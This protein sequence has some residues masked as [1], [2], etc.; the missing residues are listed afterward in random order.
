MRR[1]LKSSATVVIAAIAGIA[2]LITNAGAQS[3]ELTGPKGRAGA[4]NILLLTY[5]PS[6]SW[7][8]QGGSSMELDDAWGAGF[9]FGYNFSDRFQLNGVVSWGDRDFTATIVNSD[10]STRQ[11]NNRLDSTSLSLN[12]VYYFLK[13]AITPFVSGGVGL[14]NI[15][16]NIPTGVATTE[17]WWDPWYGYVCNINIPTKNETVLTYTAG[18]G[19]SFDI[20]PR[21]SLQSSYNKTWLDV[22][23]AANTPDFDLWRLDLIFRIP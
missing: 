16:T 19:V 14:T 1:M 4:L 21:Y 11:Y 22:R 23:R 18:L 6:M 20:N 3:D 13:G 17:C 5:S 2:V 9:G 12:G 8:G 15:D 10:G 7:G